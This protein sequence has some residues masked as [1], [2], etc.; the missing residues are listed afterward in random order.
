MDQFAHLKAPFIAVRG[1]T[2][3]EP[4]TQRTNVNRRRLERLGPLPAGLG[5]RR[6][7]RTTVSFFMPRRFA[8]DEPPAFGQLSEIRRAGLDQMS[9][10]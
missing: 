7:L 3:R 10:A 4:A 5:T 1:E 9:D 8:A 6:Y 2:C